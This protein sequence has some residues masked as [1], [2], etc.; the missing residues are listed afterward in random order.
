MVQKQVARRGRPRQY[1]PE[2]A[3]ERAVDVFWERGYSGTSLDDLCAAMEMNRPSLYAAF[4]DKHE[5]FIMAIRRYQERARARFRSAF[6]ADR[7]LLPS[8]RDYYGG[9]LTRFFSGDHGPRG[10]FMMSV[11]IMEAAQ[12]PAVRA[13]VADGMRAMDEGFEARFR[14]AREKG[15]IARRADPAA[16]ARLASGLVHSLA[17]RAR[18]GEKRQAL[19]GVI[20]AFFS[21]LGAAPAPS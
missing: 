18:A 10:C 15:D 11:A 1:D 16:L 5:L 19:E 7:P 6:A 21:A 20:E 2:V 3:L 17:I 14:L 12:D 13:V 4:G 8:L 9:M